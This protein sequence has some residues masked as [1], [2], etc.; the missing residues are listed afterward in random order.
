MD[1]DM[2]RKNVL[3]Y[4]KELKKSIPTQKS[5]L[6]RKASVDISKLD[7][8]K[9]KIDLFYER[10]ISISPMSIDKNSINILRE[11]IDL[12]KQ[13]P[14]NLKPE[15]IMENKILEQT[16][17]SKNTRRILLPSVLENNSKLLENYSYQKN[18]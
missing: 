15:N 14:Q 7:A 8:I 4:L 13:F 16:T 3:E 10:G 9:D 6:G 18:A 11:N 1:L 5:L 17:N 12:I 2:N